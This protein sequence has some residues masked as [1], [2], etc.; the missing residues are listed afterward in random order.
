[1]NRTT[2]RAPIPAP[3]WT[4]LGSELIRAAFEYARMR[5]MDKTTLPRGDGH[6]VVIFPGLAADHRVVA[7]RRARARANPSFARVAPARAPYCHWRVA[8]HARLT[9]LRGSP[10]AR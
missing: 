5:L 7:D 8:S 1:M 6:P 2:L 4:L 3:D 9:Q 10:P